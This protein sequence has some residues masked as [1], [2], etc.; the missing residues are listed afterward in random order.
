MDMGIDWLGDDDQPEEL[1]R[2]VEG[3]KYGWPYIYADGRENPQDE[4]PGEMT[5]EQWRK[6]SEAAAPAL[7]GARLAAP[8]RLLRRRPVPGR[9]V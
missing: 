9:R 8:V 1:N 5:M 2:L 7:H 3:K 4:P 6:G